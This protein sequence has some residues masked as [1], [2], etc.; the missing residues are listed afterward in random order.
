MVACAIL[1][2]KTVVEQPTISHRGHC[3][4][5]Y[6]LVAQATHA[7]L[8]QDSARINHFI[9]LITPAARK[10]QCLRRPQMRHRAWTIGW[11]WGPSRHTPRC[12]PAGVV[13]QDG[14]SSP[15]VQVDLRISA[16]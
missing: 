3:Y 2:I 1:V 14:P 9:S 6:L 4:P 13:R 12:P 7:R 15:D 11:G 8:L 16:C 5:L 10:R